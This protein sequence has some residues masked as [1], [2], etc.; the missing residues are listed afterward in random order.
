MQT[1]K[2][3]KAKDTIAHYE[4]ISLGRG[5]GVLR[6]EKAPVDLDDPQRITFQGY[7]GTIGINIVAS[8]RG[9]LFSKYRQTLEAIVRSI[10]WD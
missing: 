8:S 4:E 2:D 7:A 6:I 10:K 3:E 5:K 1:A 9:K